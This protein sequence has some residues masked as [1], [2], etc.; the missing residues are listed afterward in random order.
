LGPKTEPALLDLVHNPLEKVAS[1]TFERLH[2]GAPSQRKGISAPCVLIIAVYAIVGNKK[3]KV[4]TQTSKPLVVRGKSK[5]YYQDMDQRP[6]DI[7]RSDSEPLT[8][9]SEN[10]FKFPVKND[11][12]S[13]G[14][15]SK[16]DTCSFVSQSDLASQFSDGIISPPLESNRSSTPIGYRNYQ[17]DTLVKPIPQTA[18]VKSGSFVQQLDSPTQ[19]EPYPWSSTEYRYVPAF[20]PQ[21]L[22]PPKDQPM[23]L[24]DFISG[25]LG[26]LE[27]PVRTQPRNHKPFMFF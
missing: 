16:Q 27:R 1:A 7:S 2:L 8:P 4:C 3:Y 20:V 24:E 6:G 26:V 15:F 5:K 9:N 19:S 13:F 12:D 17:L 21:H 10:T 14:T 23:R 11:L 25:D 18:S 22:L